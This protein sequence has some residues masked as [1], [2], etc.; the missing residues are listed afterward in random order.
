MVTVGAFVVVVVFV[1]VGLMVVVVVVVVIAVVVVEAVEVNV[2]LGVLVFA[3][4]VPDGRKST[5]IYDKSLVKPGDS[6]LER[7]VKILLQTFFQK[8]SRNLN[9]VELGA[10]VVAWSVCGFFGGFS[11]VD[12]LLFFSVLLVLVSGM[13][14]FVSGL[15]LPVV[16]TTSPRGIWNKG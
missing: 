14:V 1:I 3:A 2:K 7:V 4:I 10:S 8:A 11:V 13:L 9:G 12:L 15:V 6:S 5:K 16:G